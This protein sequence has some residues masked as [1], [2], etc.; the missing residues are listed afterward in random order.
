MYTLYFTFNCGTCTV[1]SEIDLPTVLFILTQFMAVL[2]FV[3]YISVI[4]AVRKKMA[5]SGTQ[6]QSRDIKLV[7]NICFIPSLLQLFIITRHKPS[8]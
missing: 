6:G 2:M 4:F 5:L 1:F 3:A 7:K 8:F